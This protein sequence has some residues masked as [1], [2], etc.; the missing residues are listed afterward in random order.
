MKSLFHS[1]KFLLIDM[2]STVFFVV[3]F[4][5]TKNVLLSVALGVA[6]GVAEMAWERSRGRPIDAMQW[7]SLFLVVATGAATFFT[8]DP[9]FILI[10]PS[11]IY[12]IVAIVM[13]KPGWMNRY[14]PEQAIQI[15]PDIGVAFGFVWSGLM[16]LTA[17]INVV[18]AI[19]FS[20]AT[21]A[22]FMS[23]W[24]I[25]SKLSLF[26]IQYA[27]MRFIAIRRVREGRY[28][29]PTGAVSAEA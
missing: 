25:G 27:T 8:K 4:S 15:V 5:L 13:L 18:V 3:L 26:L 17:I 11:I 22:T 9:R 6:L 7:L 10:K 23:A 29:A 28:V 24:A 16:F 20:L 19:K 14:L 21:W 1:A 2:A 12:V